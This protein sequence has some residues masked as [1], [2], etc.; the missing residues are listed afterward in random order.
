VDAAGGSR[1]FGQWVEKQILPLL[2]E[3][4][5]APLDITNGLFRSPIAIERAAYRRNY[6]AA[7]GGRAAQPGLIGVQTPKGRLAIIY[8]PDDLACALVGYGGFNIRGYTP[9][10][11]QKIVTNI[12]FQT[13][14]AGPKA[15]ATAP[16]VPASP[17]SR[18]S[19]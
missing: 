12:V 5:V 17:A 16:T 13:A 15:Q 7:L 14:G 19:P 4:E 6:A 2:P 1:P 11:A 3:G 10:C 8:S 9:E 18:P